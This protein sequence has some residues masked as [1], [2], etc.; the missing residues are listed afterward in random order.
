MTEHKPDVKEDAGTTEET[1]SEPQ[2][3]R[4]QNKNLDQVWK[5]Q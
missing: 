2:Y 4:H 3:H 5:Q 1:R